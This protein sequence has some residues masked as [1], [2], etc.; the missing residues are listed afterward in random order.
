MCS[1]ASCGED[2]SAAT[3]FV[4]DARRR[5][6]VGAATGN[7]RRLRLLPVAEWGVL[8]LRATDVFRKAHSRRMV[9]VSA[10]SPSRAAVMG[11]RI[12]EGSRMAMEHVAAVMVFCNT[13]TRSATRWCRA[14]VPPTHFELANLAKR[15][16][17]TVWLFGTRCDADAGF[18]HSVAA[19]ARSATNALF[20]ALVSKCGLLLPLST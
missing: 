4:R 6:F 8:R 19:T 1:G 11:C 16:K 10:A 2:P 17:E 7:A 15:L 3:P 18:Y 9:A 14:A 5:G 20:L 13:W 12:E